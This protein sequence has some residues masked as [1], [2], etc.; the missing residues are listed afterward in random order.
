MPCGAYAEI[1]RCGLPLQSRL[2]VVLFLSGRTGRLSLRI[3][4]TG[5]TDSA[6]IDTGREQLPD[7]ML[8]HYCDL[9]DMQSS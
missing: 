4:P 8:A 6:L 9:S 5:R 2:F 7:P 3:E 1:I